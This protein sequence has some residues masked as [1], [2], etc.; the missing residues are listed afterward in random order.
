MSSL[1]RD[2][3]ARMDNTT[4]PGRSFADSDII[5]GDQFWKEVTWH[6]V[7]DLGVPPGEGVVIRLRLDRAKLFGIQFD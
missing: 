4:L 6:G 5:Q 2:P 7:A 3:L 1:T